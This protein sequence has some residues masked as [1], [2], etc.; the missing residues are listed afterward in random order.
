[1]QAV[2]VEG[3]RSDFV[4]VESS[5][6]RISSQ[7][8]SFPYLH[9]W[10]SCRHQVQSLAIRWR[11]HVQQNHQK[12][13]RPTHAARRPGLPHHLGETVVH[14]LPPTEM[15]YTECHMQ[16]EE[17]HPSVWAPWTHPWEHQHNGVPG[18]HHPGWP[19]VGIPHQLY[20]KQSQQDA[21]LPPAQPQDWQQEDKGNCVQSPCSPTSWV[22]SHCMGSLHC[23]QD[24]GHWEGP[25]H[26]CL[27]DGSP[28]DT[29]RHHALT[30]Y[31][32]P[33]TGQRSK[34]NAG[35]LGWTCSTSATM[36]SSLSTPATC[37]NHRQQKEQHL[38]L[39]HPILQDTIQ[40]DVLPQDH[41]RLEQTA[42]GDSDSWVSGLLQVQAEIAPV[43]TNSKSPPLHHH[44]QHPLPWVLST[45]T[46]TQIFTTSSVATESS[47]KWCWPLYG[48]RRRVT[49]SQPEKPLIQGMMDGCSVGY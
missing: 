46:M 2:V 34:N 39:W 19:E 22:C 36:V 16:A 4:P 14:G 3:E 8:K 21:R 29:A 26:S 7:A 27:Q 33:S 23:K 11:H 38:Q 25:T 1:M 15:L 31:L 37:P 42:P 6:A 17:D 20:C 10:P 12:G 47:T 41:T 9:Q 43:N 35:E 45:T 28:T 18:S 49:R 24:P 40:T 32:M 44:P 30:P 13:R 48:R 5:S